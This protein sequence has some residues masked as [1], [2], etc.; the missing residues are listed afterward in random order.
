M[1]AFNTQKTLNGNP[2]LIPTIAAQL[3]SSFLADGYNVCNQP[4]MSGGADVSIS[5]GGIFK[6]VLGMRTALKISLKPQGDSI[7]FDA[8]VGIFGQQVI[9][10]LIMWFYA[11]PILITQIWGLVKQTKLDDKALTIA[12]NVITNGK[13]TSSSQDNEICPECGSKFLNDASFCIVC[14]HKR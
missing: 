4:L 9:P 3:E 5:K 2:A 14:G 11:W 13:S 1:G 6:A 7:A 10:T 8:S 12:E